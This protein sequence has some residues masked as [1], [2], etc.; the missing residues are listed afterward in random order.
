[1]TYYRLP[2]RDTLPDGAY[3]RLVDDAL[4]RALAEAGKAGRHVS[5]RP[6][7]DELLATHLARA[8]HD[9]AFLAFRATSGNDADEKRIELARRLLGVLADTGA[10][11]ADEASIRSELLEAVWSSRLGTGANAPSAPRDSLVGT[12]L[13]VN[14]RDE[15]VLSSLDS[16]FESADEVDLLCSFVKR[17]GVRKVLDRVRSFV[18]GGG[19]MRVLSTTYLGAS[20]VEA[21][22]ELARHGVEVRISYDEETTRLH[23]K[24]WLFRRKTGFH[25][26]YVG[27]S[28][29]SHVAITEGLE[30]NVRLCALDSPQVIERFGL[31]FDSY[32]D[33]PNAGFEPFDEE[34]ARTAVDRARQ[35]DRAPTARRPTYDLAPKP[36]QAR[37][38]ESLE[39]ARALGKR[40]HLVV[41]ATGTGKT[42]L[43]AFDFRSLY[44]RGDAKSLLFIAHRREILEQ[45]RDAFRDVVGVEGD[46]LT[47]QDE[48]KQD[49]F[50]FATNVTVRNLV[51]DRPS[52][53]L[54]YDYVVVDEVHHA[55]ASTYEEILA[56]LRP[57][58]LLGLTATPER[59]DGRSID[60][61]F[62]LPAVSDLRIWDAIDEQLLV[63]FSYFAI[64]DELVDLRRV[65]W[66]RGVGYDE[67]ELSRVLTASDAWVEQ[68]VRALDRHL[69]DIDGMR[70]LAFC[71]D[72]RHA[73]Y[74]AERL[75]ARGVP[76][77]AITH[78][79]QAPS[80]R[81]PLIEALRS[82]A[83]D[84]PR[85]LCAV[86]V[87]NEGVDIPEVD[88]LLLLRP[89]ESPTVFLQQLGR[90]LRR[91]HGK[92]SLTVLD[93]VAVQHDEFRL[94]RRYAALL[95]IPRPELKRAVEAGFPYLPSGCTIRLGK[96]TR[97]QVLRAIR[98]SLGA[99]L[100]KLVEAV[101]EAGDDARLGAFLDDYELELPDLY[102]KRRSWTLLRRDAGLRTAPVDDEEAKA[103]AEVQRL[104]H[105]D[106]SRRLDLWRRL[107]EHPELALATEP[108]RR[109]ARMLFAVVYGLAEATD[110][111][112]LRPR[113]KRHAALRAE[114]REL[115]DV[116]A[117]RSAL[118]P[119]ELPLAADVPLVG[120]GRYLTDELVAAFDVRTKDG[121]LYLPQQ[122]VI[123]L[124][125]Y[126]L[127]LVTID[128]SAKSKTPHLQYEDRALSPTEF[129]WQSQART[130]L[131]SSDGQRHVAHREL[132]VTPVLFVREQGKDARGL[133]VPYT[134][135]GPCEHVSHEGERPITIRWRL[136]ASMPE[137]LYLSLKPAA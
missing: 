80:E 129:Q 61:H 10:L 76:A 47:G 39:A 84:R 125:G 113:W 24:A 75:R 19:R 25:T 4:A 134:Y 88:T 73:K 55:A 45:A 56:S 63:P 68:V 36:H 91:A 64:D 101:R 105:A 42:L 116:L 82:G 32:W 27:S 72:T 7:A 123:R 18:Q 118:L 119:R 81:R 62:D 120:H 23:A 108:E 11:H 133:A 3:E 13:L 78:D 132:G 135:L 127:L 31:L 87:F 79:A 22:A 126:D 121:K 41:A 95:G 44:R 100:E 131:A 90:G 28:N 122:G 111:D 74:V 109:L 58:H 110:L 85:V 115:V 104:V 112:A 40:R 137:R 83:S 124:A 46:L 38:L 65:K 107:A 71:V 97:E 1:M 14:R 94:D 9:A 50:L 98:R 93:F 8:I 48:P 136:A 21:L 43:A 59:A 52:A 89:T 106:D 102:E 103:L 70:A 51:R 6:A 26:A 29:L 16:E 66:R 67:G 117:A 60:R 57:P 20:E 54:D 30:W 69:V 37:I 15:N 12:R 53:P 34:R 33:H 130:T 99:N 2:Y 35:R 5:T 96:K 86:D 92:D 114:L 77:E 17:S 128:K 49:R